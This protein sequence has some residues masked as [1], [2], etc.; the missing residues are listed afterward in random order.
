[1]FTRS[2]GDS[3]RGIGR[4]AWISAGCL[5]WINYAT[6]VGSR[7]AAECENN[8]TDEQA[9]A[10]DRSGT[11]RQW[12]A[13]C[14]PEEGLSA[15]RLRN[16]PPHQMG[17]DGGLPWRLLPA[18]VRALEPRPRRAEPGGADRSAQQ[19]LLFL[20]HRVVAAGSILFYR[21]ADRGRADP[22]PDEFAG[23]T[24]LVRI[25]L[26]ADGLDRPVLCRRADD[27]GRPPRAYAKGRRARHAEAGT[28]R[29]AYAETFDLADDRMVDRRRL[30]S[31]FQRR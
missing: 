21:P 9:R 6:E 28:L 7:L 10:P 29:R 11:R 3:D 23:W 24:H 12:A 18:A 14:G 16:L 25:P 19:P 17:A 15:K 4:Q 5:S 20:L 13:L 1:M 26:P 31:L 22:V 30:G 2:A 27:R 8:P